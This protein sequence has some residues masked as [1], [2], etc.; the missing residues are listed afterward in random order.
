[1]KEENKAVIPLLNTLCPSLLF[2][3]CGCITLLMFAT[4]MWP[5]SHVLSP[6][7][8]FLHPV[9]VQLVVWTKV[10]NFIFFPLSILWFKSFKAAWDIWLQ[11]KSSTDAQTFQ[12]LCLVLIWSACMSS[13]SNQVIDIKVEQNR[14]EARALKGANRTFFP[15]SH[16]SSNQYSLAMSHCPLGLE[17]LTTQC[18]LAFAKLFTLPVTQNNLPFP[19][20]IYHSLP[21]C[22]NLASFAYNACSLLAHLAH[23]Y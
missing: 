7:Q 10:Q 11:I 1:M 4:Q 20:D 9:L 15:D 18:D 5:F 19:K 23:S 13:L 6:G 14:L 2:S 17:H 16:L 21:P 12:T 22:F 8:G 3:Q